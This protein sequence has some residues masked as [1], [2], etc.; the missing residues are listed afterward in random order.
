MHVSCLTMCFICNC[1][2]KELCIHDSELYIDKSTYKHIPTMY[3]YIIKISTI[4]TYILCMYLVNMHVCEM[5]VFFFNSAIPTDEK[6]ET[7]FQLVV[8][9]CNFFGNIN[10]TKK[11]YVLKSA[12]PVF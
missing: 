6:S 9:F 7:R 2:I 8:N 10:K 3:A 5:Q 12:A 1:S 4:Y 11:S